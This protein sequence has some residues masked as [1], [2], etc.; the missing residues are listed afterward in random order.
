MISTQSGDEEQDKVQIGLTLAASER[1]D[2]LIA[3]GWFAERQDAYRVAIAV[4]LSRSLVAGPAEMA[5]ARTSYN[6]TG[7]IDRDGS[8]RRM[9]AIVAPA[10]S[11]RP[12][13]FAERLAHAGLEFLAERISGGDT[14]FEA[15]SPPAT[16]I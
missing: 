13:A 2:Q 4:A 11:R 3:T 1:L 9:I 7:G 8:V 15:L 16:A 12:A 6:F 10:E 5:G 14:L